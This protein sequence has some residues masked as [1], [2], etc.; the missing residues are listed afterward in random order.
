MTLICTYMRRWEKKI[1]FHVYKYKFVERLSTRKSSILKLSIWCCWCI[2][3]CCCCTQSS[4]SNT[5]WV[6]V[7]VIRPFA[8]KVIDPTLCTVMPTVAGYSFARWTNEHTHTQQHLQQHKSRRR[9]RSTITSWPSINSKSW[10][11]W[12]SQLIL[13][14]LVYFFAKIYNNLH[15]SILSLVWCCCCCCKIWRRRRR[16]STNYQIYR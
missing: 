5:W 12:H 4:S 9:S 1:C 10:A 3:M 11:V 6:C 14:L 7:Y 15:S 16:N 2:C 13:V 8:T